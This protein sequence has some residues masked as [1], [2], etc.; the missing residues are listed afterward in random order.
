MIKI[1]VFGNSLVEEDKIALE[2]MPVL[3]KKFPSIQFVEF[4][5]VEEIQE[6]G[7][8]LVIIDAVKGLEKIRVIENLDLIETDSIVS[9]HDF[10]LAYNLKLMKKVGLID[11]VKII[12]T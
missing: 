3:R 9:M 1:L 6:H 11:S 2:I 5:A 7:K 12:A 10:D 8:D 4:D